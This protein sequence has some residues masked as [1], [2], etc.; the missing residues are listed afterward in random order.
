TA[1]S[2]AGWNCSGTNFVTCTR[3]DSLAAAG[4]YPAISLTVSV[5]GGGPGVTNFASVTGG[6]DSQFRNASDP[7]NI[8]APTLAI[9]KTHTGDFTVGQSGTYT[10]TVSN[11]G[12][13]ATSGTVTVNDFLPFSMVATATSGTGWNCSGTSFVSCSRSDVLA[14]SSSY[15]PITL[16]VSVGGG[17]SSVTNTANV[18]GG[19]DS[20]VHFASDP[21]NIHTPTLAIAKSHTGNF[22]AGQTGAY[23]ITVSNAGTIASAGNVNVNDFMPSGLTVTAVNASGWNCSGTPTS[24]MNC[25]RSASLAGGASY[26]AITLTVSVAPTTP[27]L[28]INQANLSG[29]GDSSNHSANDPTIINLPDLA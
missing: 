6:G 1:A 11:S 9:T 26:P 28:V 23:T 7:T 8:N 3:S 12:T 25:S 29:G 20:V 19:G 13:I 22:T 21:A 18:T 16:T 10:I 17:A 24:F 14:A 5:N 27:V 2:G 4:S 15:P